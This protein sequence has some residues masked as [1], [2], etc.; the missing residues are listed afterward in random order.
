MKFTSTL[1]VLITLVSCGGNSNKT[2]EATKS[3]IQL[4]Y[5]I[6]PED[7]DRNYFTVTWT[8]TLGLSEGYLP[9]KFLSRPKEIWCIVNN[10]ENDTLGY[11]KGMSMPHDYCSFKATDSLVTLNF[12]IGLNILPERFETDTTGAMAYIKANQTPIEYEPIE[13][14]MNTDLRQSFTVEL[15]EKN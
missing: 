9:D 14:N 1:L 8:D 12:M 5:E 4:T 13:V 7:Y 15:K 11:Y 3:I 2:H 6:I 10:R